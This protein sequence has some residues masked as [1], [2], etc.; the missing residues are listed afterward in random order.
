MGD[1]TNTDVF[2]IRKKALLRDAV[3]KIL[4]RGLKYV[5]VVDENKKLVGII[6]RSSL[7]DMVYETIWGEEEGGLAVPT[8]SATETP[9]KEQEEV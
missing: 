9:V 6:T 5:P 3:Q 1:I 8:E 7:V 4:K 2:F